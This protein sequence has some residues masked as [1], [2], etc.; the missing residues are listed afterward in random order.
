MVE[1]K[2]PPHRDTPLRNDCRARRLTDRMEEEKLEWPQAIGDSS[3]AVHIQIL[4]SGTQMM[5]ARHRND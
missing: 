4:E 1:R 3:D 2:Q 5:T